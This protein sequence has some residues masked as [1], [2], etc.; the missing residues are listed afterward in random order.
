MY[1]WYFC[2]RRRRKHSR[3]R[4]SSRIRCSLRAR[5]VLDT[6]RHAT[7]STTYSRQRAQLWETPWRR[8]HVIGT[9]AHRACASDQTA[10]RHYDYDDHGASSRDARVRRRRVHSLGKNNKNYADR[11]RA[12][13]V[14]T[15]RVQR[16]RSNIEATELPLIDSASSRHWNPVVSRSHA[17]CYQSGDKPR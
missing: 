2:R 3:Y 4:P 11:P 5:V 1:A 6:K 15:Q 14:N 7:S 17:N 9:C 8:V 13:R 10:Q 16:R 12:D